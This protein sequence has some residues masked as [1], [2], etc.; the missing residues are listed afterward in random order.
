[1]ADGKFNLF[2][3]SY[4]F[5]GKEGAD[6]CIKT[7]GKVKIKWGNKYIDLV[8]DGKINVD[9][10]FI[11]KVES[12]E[13]IGGEDGIYVTEDGE[14]TIV[15]DGQQTT[16]AGNE[17]EASY[18]AYVD[19]PDKT[20]EEKGIAM[21]NIGILFNTASEYEESGIQNGLA[22]IADENKV[23]TAN[24]GVVSEL[25]F[26]LPN[27]ITSPVTINIESG[28]YALSLDGFKSDN[29]TSLAIGNGS[30][31]LE[32]YA[33]E[34]GKHIESNNKID[35]SIDDKTPISI[36]EDAIDVDGNLT[37]L[38][39]RELITNK[40]VSDNGDEDNGF[41]LI[42]EGGESTLYVDNVVERNNVNSTI[43][44][45]AKEFY[46]AKQNEELKPGRL[47]EIEFMNEWDCT[48]ERP[49][50]RF[51]E[52]EAGNIT[53]IPKNIHYLIIRAISENEHEAFGYFRDHESWTIRYDNIE[54]NTQHQVEDRD[55][56]IIDLTSWGR[57]TYMMDEFGNEASY[58]FKHLQF[59]DPDTGQ[60]HYTYKYSNESTIIDGNIVADGSCTSEIRGN[61]LI[62]DFE[63]L[64]LEDF[65]NR[66]YVLGGNGVISISGK[67][68]N[69]SIGIISGNFT[70]E[71]GNTDNEEIRPFH[72]N[73]FDCGE[74][75]DMIIS[76]DFYNNNIKTIDT[77]SN[78]SPN[79]F[80]NN[81][82]DCNSLIIKGAEVS[83]NKFYGGDISI[84][85][86]GDVKHNTING[87]TITANGNSFTYN[88]VYGELNNCTLAPDMKYCHFHG[89]VSR[90]DFTRDGNEIFG[91][92]KHVDI[93]V[94]DGELRTI[95]IPDTIFPGMI[96]MY[97]GRKPVPTG[98]SI[99]D[100]S[101]GT[102]N[103]IDRFVKGSTTAGETGGAE[104][105]EI[106]LTVDQMPSHTHEVSAGSTSTDGDHYHTMGPYGNSGKEID[107][108]NDYYA[109]ALGGSTAF[110]T[111]TSGAHSHTV[112]ISIAE[113][114]GNQP[115]DITPPYYTLI[116][117]MYVG[118]SDIYY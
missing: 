62:V 19:Q 114:G 9:T 77:F 4:E 27:P 64:K 67:P 60:W 100:G 44:M 20:G 92:D 99:C 41:M 93:Y 80:F 59:V 3:R 14:V 94:N 86:T 95:S 17:E 78:E 47:Y 79:G 113:T 96:V 46:R 91:S 43:K 76:T 116:F 90:Q 26:N 75:V 107:H 83:Y 10:D 39:D 84:E 66:A 118:Y 81:E 70:V 71:N 57:I 87:S 30:N 12:A 24:E 32:I 33:E 1:M 23:Y 105:G 109:F 115:I 13:D 38:N 29:G 21:S 53:F 65:P 2:G 40:V 48:E 111:D 6:F 31:I 37:I 22:Y 7:K 58:D 55:G 49:E 106:T 25:K 108:G 63:N 36:K 56:N 50:D 117:I 11:K 18:V 98:W 61:R 102:P 54:I 110:A 68:T 5:V 16:I 97:D 45:T 8:K 34:D 89:V 85:M 35:I 69:N 15:S 74:I 72:D 101:N 104:G 88:T 51:E 112:D 73:V 103:L 42:N 52:D 82:V 28:D